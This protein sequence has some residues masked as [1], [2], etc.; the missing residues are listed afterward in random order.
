MLEI[1]SHNKPV[2]FHVSRDFAK[3][4]I[5]EHPGK[6]FQIKD[7]NNPTPIKCRTHKTPMIDGNNIGIIIPSRTGSQSKVI[8]LRSLYSLEIEGREYKVM[9]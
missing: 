4:L 2:E 8:N 1:H 5:A 6:Y 3:K 9:Q 7:V